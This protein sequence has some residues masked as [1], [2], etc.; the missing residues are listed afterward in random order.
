MKPY[1]LKFGILMGIASLVI[2][3]FRPEKN[4]GPITNNDIFKQLQVTEPIKAKLQTSC[5]DCHSNQ[6]K[7]PWYNNVAPVSWMLANHVKEGKAELNFSEWGT[8]S[9]RKQISLLSNMS[10][11]IADKSMP[12]PSYIL[13]H[14]GAKFSDSEVEN[15]T[16]W[17]DKTIKN[18]I[19]K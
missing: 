9:K 4:N 2:Q 15:V 1:L 12:L 13:I 6:T 10:E 17:S 11:V 5:Y 18:L 3:F 16:L 19:Q 8:Y 7:Y 14:K